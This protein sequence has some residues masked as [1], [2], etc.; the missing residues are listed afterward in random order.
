MIVMDSMEPVF[1]CDSLD[2]I[3]VEAIVFFSRVL[4]IVYG[5]PK[6]FCQKVNDFEK[7]EVNAIRSKCFAAV[8]NNIDENNDGGGGGNGGVDVDG[9]V[10]ER[11]SGREGGVGD[12]D[13]GVEGVGG[14]E[15]DNGGVA[16][17]VGAE[18]GGGGDDGDGDGADD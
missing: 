3:N 7:A 9:A 1:G 15:D 2:I 10:G 12:G 14:G 5:S 4:Y 6:T 18:G 13:G 8:A 16:K 17:N 11:V